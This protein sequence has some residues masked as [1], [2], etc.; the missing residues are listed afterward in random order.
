MRPENLF[1]DLALS[2][3]RFPAILE[4]RSRFV[5]GLFY[6]TR[7]DESNTAPASPHNNARRPQRVLGEMRFTAAV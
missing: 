5:K 2:K 1:R 4:C 6:P 7:H 3:A